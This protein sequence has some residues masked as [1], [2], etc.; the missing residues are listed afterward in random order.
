MTRGRRAAPEK[1]RYVAGVLGPTNR[2][3]ISPD[4]NDPAFRNITLTSWWQPT[5]N[6]PK[7][8]VKAV[9]T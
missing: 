8:L 3:S 1:P 5:V 2:T 7:A 6:Q 9:P 4:V